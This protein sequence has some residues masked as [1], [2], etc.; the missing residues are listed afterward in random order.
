MWFTYQ[1]IYKMRKELSLLKVAAVFLF[2]PL[3]SLNLAADKAWARG[4]FTRTC[5]DIKLDSSAGT[6]GDV[7]LTAKCL[8]RNGR[9]IKTKFNLDTAITNSDGQLRWVNTAGKFSRSCPNIFLQRESERTTLKADCKQIDGYL[10]RTHLHLDER[11]ANID[12]QLSR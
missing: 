11:I 10:L 5:T 8:K 2:T 12:G 7:Y 6:P 3:V 9:E 1:V 4:G